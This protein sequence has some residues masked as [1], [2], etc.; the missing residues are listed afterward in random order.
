MLSRV[1]RV[2][3]QGTAG[4]II[5]SAVDKRSAGT[6]GGLRCACPPY[7]TGPA[8]GWI[9]RAARCPGPG[10]AVARAAST[11]GRAMPREFGM[12]PV[13]MPAQCSGCRML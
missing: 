6:A 4:L 10:T 13:A 9:R 3:R 1:L 12:N 5:A 7:N 11:G 8:V 2:H